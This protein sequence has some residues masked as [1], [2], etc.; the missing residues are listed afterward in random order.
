MHQP[1]E[2]IRHPMQ[3]YVLGPDFASTAQSES[4]QVRGEIVALCAR[5]VSLYRWEL[6]DLRVA[7][8]AAGFGKVPQEA[9]DPATP[10]WH[11]LPMTSGLGVHFWWLGAGPT[12]LRSVGRFNHAPALEFDRFAEA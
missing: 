2:H 12:E 6:P 8:H 11:P 3:P 5:I 10:L 9:L 4:R 7:K 1:G